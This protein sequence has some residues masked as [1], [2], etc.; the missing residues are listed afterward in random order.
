[1]EP[2]ELVEPDEL[3]VLD[4]L[5]GAAAGVLAALSLDFLLSLDA[6]SDTAGF[7]SDVPDSEDPELFGA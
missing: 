3:G 4:E 7:A 1:M 5:E 2:D 6:G